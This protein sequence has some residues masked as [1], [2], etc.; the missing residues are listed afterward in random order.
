MHMQ[1][2]SICVHEKKTHAKEKDT[3][4]IMDKI[5]TIFVHMSNW[6]EPTS[7]WGA[8]VIEQDPSASLHE[9]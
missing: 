6:G 3:M 1:L 2:V 5:H 9:N 7:D 4:I 8:L